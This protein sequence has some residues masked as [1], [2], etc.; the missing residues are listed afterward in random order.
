MT[1]AESEGRA[2]AQQ[3]VWA[4]LGAA[5]IWGLLPLYLRELRAL[6]APVVIAYR[7]VLCCVFVLSW[8]ARR[9][10]LRLVLRALWERH[11][12]SRLLASALLISVNWLL[13]VWAV[14]H[15]RVLE[16]SLGY[17]IN[18]LL[19]VLLGVVFL[20]ERLRRMQWL[21]V[22]L[23]ALGVG[24]MS[25]RAG[26]LPVIACLLAL[27]FGLY[28]LIRKTVAVEAMVGLGA[29]TLLLTPLG[30]AYLAWV[31]L[32]GQGAF[33]QLPAR[34]LAL[35][36]CGGVITGLPLWLFSLGA[37]RLRYA[38]VGLLG[39]VSP[40]LQ[41]L[42]GVYVFHERFGAERAWGFGLIWTALALYS[43]DTLRARTAA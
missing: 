30:A 42:L 4:L 41:L 5:A 21:A 14:A 20:R 34:S 19:N 6:P 7:L 10:E 25:W 36:M 29:E 24:F 22:F 27:S 12:R 39:Y 15:G 16:A 18:P 28:G 13:Y 1:G 9:G 26:A 2:R 38:T 17:F 40:T 35:L 31:E 43:L 37:R 32:H 3:G 33:A 23:A 11:T 8:L